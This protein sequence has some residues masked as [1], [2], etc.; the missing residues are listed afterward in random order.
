MLNLG[1]GVRTYYTLNICDMV[2]IAELAAATINLII[3]LPFV[4]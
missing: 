3:V 1:V 4:V 2:I